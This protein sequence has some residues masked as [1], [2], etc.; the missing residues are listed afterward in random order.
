[1]QAN[2]FFFQ[3]CQREPK[4]H[5]MAP[6][7]SDALDR[8][9]WTEWLRGILPCH[10]H[11]SRESRKRQQAVSRSCDDLHRQRGEDKEHRGSCNKQD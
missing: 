1:M 5:S 6:L 4:E 10:A 11:T 7:P 9:L 2:P 3:A 8:P